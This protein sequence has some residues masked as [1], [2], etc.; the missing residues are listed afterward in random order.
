MVELEITDN[1]WWNSKLEIYKKVIKKLTRLKYR[2]KAKNKLTYLELLHN[3]LNNLKQEYAKEIIES[4]NNAWRKL[5][6]ETKVWGKPYKILM[7]KF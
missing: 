3:V 7:E 4:K 5:I 2:F 6:S 1:T